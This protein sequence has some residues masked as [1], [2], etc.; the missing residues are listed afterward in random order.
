MAKIKAENRAHLKELS[1]KAVKHFRKLS[2][3]MLTHNI[4]QGKLE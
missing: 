2:V 1:I 3:C 4:Q